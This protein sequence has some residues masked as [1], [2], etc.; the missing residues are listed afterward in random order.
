MSFS[1]G[2]TLVVREM[3]IIPQCDTKN[4]KEETLTM[5]SAVRTGRNRHSDTLLTGMQNG[6][7][8]LETSDSS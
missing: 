8:T 7:A 4:Q 3:Q 5:L 2:Q 1:R 6:R